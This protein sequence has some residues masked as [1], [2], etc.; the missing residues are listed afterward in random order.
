MANVAIIGSEKSG[1]TSL[2][3]KLGKKGTE[4]DITLYNFVKGDRNI[5][6]WMQMDIHLLLKR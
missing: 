4:S 1:R 2:A 6:S 3:G 5:H